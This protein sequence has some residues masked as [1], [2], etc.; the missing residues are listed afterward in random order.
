LV[1]VFCAGEAGVGVGGWRIGDGRF[2]APRRVVRVEK[3]EATWP[4][5]S[6]GELVEELELLLVGLRPGRSRPRLAIS[7]AWQL[8]GSERV[9]VLSYL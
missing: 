3:I 9:A 6:E 8:G 5:L 1:G 2:F 7:K 4:R